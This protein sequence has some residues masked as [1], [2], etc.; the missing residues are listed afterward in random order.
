MKA[1]KQKRCNSGMTRNARSNFREIEIYTA[2][3]ASHDEKGRV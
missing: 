1:A 3:F 2:Y